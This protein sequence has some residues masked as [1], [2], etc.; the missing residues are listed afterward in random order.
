M[1]DCCELDCS[2]EVAITEAETL[3]GRELL[4]AI[5]R[6]RYEGRVAFIVARRDFPGL[7]DVLKVFPNEP[8]VL[9]RQDV[10]LPPCRKVSS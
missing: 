6:E 7:S 3:K 1:T 4:A 8:L 5:F 2:Q 9:P 10:A